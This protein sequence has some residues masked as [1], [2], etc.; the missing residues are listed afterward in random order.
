MVTQQSM[1]Q[2]VNGYI[3][4]K[5]EAIEALKKA[6]TVL[7]QEESMRPHTTFDEDDFPIYSKEWVVLENARADAQLEYQTAALRLEKAKEAMEIF[8]KYE[9]TRITV[10]SL[11]QTHADHLVV[12][13]QKRKLERLSIQLE[14][15]IALIETV[16]P[17]GGVTRVIR[18]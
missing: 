4:T 1:Q 6:R 12:D 7:E 11:M 17:H 15:A 9:N 13:V 8:G 16:H 14:S 2:L 3:K 5:N 10:E 18:V